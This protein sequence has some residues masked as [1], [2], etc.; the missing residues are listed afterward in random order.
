[1]AASLLAGTRLCLSNAAAGA[2]GRQRTTVM[3]VVHRASAAFQHAG[4]AHVCTAAAAAVCP[5]PYVSKPQRSYCSAGHRRSPVV[6][7]PIQQ[8][9]QQQ[10]PSRTMSGM[11]GMSE[12]EEP[13]E[14]PEVV[15]VEQRIQMFAAEN[16]GAMPSEEQVEQWRGSAK[17]FMMLCM[18]FERRTGQA[19]NE[20]RA[21]VLQAFVD[22]V[23]TRTYYA[24]ELVIMAELETEWKRDHGKEAT[25]ADDKKLAAMCFERLAED[26]QM[27]AGAFNALDLLCT[28]AAPLVL[29]LHPY[30]YTGVLLA[31]TRFERLAEDKYMLAGACDVLDCCYTT[32]STLVY[33][34][35]A[36]FGRRD[37]EAAQDE[38]CAALT[39]VDVDAQERE[40]AA[41]EERHQME[42]ETEQH[43]FQMLTNARRAF[44]EAYGR[45]PAINELQGTLASALVPELLGFAA[46]EELRPLEDFY[47]ALPPLEGPRA[48][49]AAE[50]ESVT[51]PP[52]EGPREASAEQVESIMRAWAERFVAPLKL[53]PFAGSATRPLHVYASAAAASAA[54]GVAAA[55][56]STPTFDAI[57]RALAAVWQ[58]AEAFDDDMQR[59]HG[60]GGDAAA[61][62]AAAAR[63]T[64][65][66]PLPALRALHWP[67]FEAFCELATTGLRARGTPLAAAAA[68]S[69][70]RRCVRTATTRARSRRRAAA[71]R[72]TC[73]GARRG[74]R[75]TSCGATRWRR[76]ARASAPPSS[77]R[78]LRRWAGDRNFVR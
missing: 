50:V 33:C 3:K 5:R 46:S 62:A 57:M 44:T 17:L 18:G 2:P 35:N 47:K 77:A 66:V 7:G 56:D 8:Q 34:S 45:E 16:G 63:A 26:K 48:A 19:M 58:A 40:A 42:Q 30:K 51:L 65:L 11:S 23:R 52:L 78:S 41:K 28:A 15:W 69:R 20:A 67:V 61:A 29:L 49:S 68:A 74:R 31:A 12:S 59:A 43:Q 1:M 72:R 13:E 54:A 75:C 55:D 25:R 39:A 73:G 53:C 22:D 37:F 6:H 71:T 38:M 4:N 60:G 32:V 21:G 70:W 36:Q 10:Q 27:L 9:Q 14:D 64:A 24:Q 76:R